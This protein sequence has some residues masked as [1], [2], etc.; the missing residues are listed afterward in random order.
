MKVKIKL[1][2]NLKGHNRNA[3]NIHNK[4]VRGASQYH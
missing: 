2:E 1:I 4:T 3:K